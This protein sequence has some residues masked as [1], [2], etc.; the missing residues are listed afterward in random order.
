MA[1]GINQLNGRFRFLLFIL[2]LFI[3]IIALGSITSPTQ[4]MHTSTKGPISDINNSTQSI[5]QTQSPFIEINTSISNQFDGLSKLEFVYTVDYNNDSMDDSIL[6]ATYAN[7]Q[8]IIVVDG[9]TNGILTSIDSIVKHDREYTGRSQKIKTSKGSNEIT[10]FFKKSNLCNLITLDLNSK[11]I[12]NIETSCLAYQLIFDFDDDGYDDIMTLDNVGNFFVWEFWDPGG[13]ARGNKATGNLRPNTLPLNSF[14]NFKIGNFTND[15]VMDFALTQ[16]VN[17]ESTSIYI[18]DGSSYTVVSNITVNYH[19]DYI[20]PL[21]TNNLG[22]DEIIIFSSTGGIIGKNTT[23]GSD[24]NY[25]PFNTPIGNFEVVELLSDVTGDNINDI[26]V[27]TSTSASIIFNGANG[28]VVTMSFVVDGIKNSIRPYNQIILSQYN[29]KPIMAAVSGELAIQFY[30]F[31][32]QGVDMIFQVSWNSLLMTNDLPFDLG[33]YEII[34]SDFVLN[35]DQDKDGLLSYDEFLLGTSDLNSD[36]DNDTVSDL[37]ELDLELNPIN[38]DTDGDKMPDNYEILH[39]LKWLIADGGDDIDDDGLSNF[40]EYLHNLDPRNWDCDG[41]GL[42]DGWEVMYG[43]DPHIALIYLDIDNDGLDEQKEYNFHTDPTKWDTDNDTMSDFYEYTYRN[44]TSGEA[45][46]NPNNPLDALLDNDHDGLTNMIE[47]Q[48]GSNP[49]KKDTDSDGMSDSYEFH[50][51]LK[52]TIND[53]G[54][55]KDHDGLN[56]GLE[57]RLGLKANNPLDGIIIIIVFSLLLIGSIFEIFLYNKRNKQSK[58]KGF[59]NYWQYRS[60]KKRGFTSYDSYKHSLERGFF[61]NEAQTLLVSYGFDTTTSLLIMWHKISQILESFLNDKQKIDSLFEFGL[62]NSLTTYQEKFDS[63]QSIYTELLGN[64][65]Q[66]TQSLSEI[67]TINDL[68]SRMKE[69]P[70]TNLSNEDIQG[71][72]SLFDEQIT[73]YETLKNQYEQL[74][75]ERKMWFK[76][77]PALLSVIDMTA[78]GSKVDLAEISKV[79]GVEDTHT[80]SLLLAIID[81]NRFIGRFSDETNQFIKATKIDGYLKFAMDKFGSDLKEQDD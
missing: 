12:D 10:L 74:S 44:T 66:L 42:P 53:A 51:G 75:N 28:N 30:R 63:S 76:P 81:E 1:I 72:K 50:N 32:S 45:G 67:D 26:I 41:D 27:F 69:F 8:D 18:V 58:Q 80:K 57:A 40:D 35:E 70:F 60:L 38:N 5:I 78:D 46:L 77:W 55:D 3:Q 71:Q 39:D 79:L 21:N 25:T 62:T 43:L 13:I 14:S 23:D 2:L 59:K 37:K 11:S 64:I 47:A 61:T 54:Q 33:F 48:F 15:G 9:K 19:V 68:I 20:E 56:N 24:I 73:R 52:G 36:S 34:S 16:S 4:L 65:K 29:G 17:N 6:L 31:M 7:K 22:P 49:F